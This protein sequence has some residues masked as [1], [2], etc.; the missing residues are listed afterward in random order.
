MKEDILSIINHFGVQHQ[1][2]KFAE[3]VFELQEAI[4]RNEEAAYNWYENEM[5]DR[6]YKK[7]IIEEIADVLHL[8]EQFKLYYDISNEDIKE[9]FQAKVKRTISEINVEINKLK[10]EK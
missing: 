10:E 1:Q 6:D 8:L 7:H 3:E 4:T 5:T 2:K 9:I